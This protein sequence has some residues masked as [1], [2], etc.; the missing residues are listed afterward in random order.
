MVVELQ[1]SLFDPSLDQ[2]VRGLEVRRSADFRLIFQPR[3]CLVVLEGSNLG[4]VLI[5]ELPQ[6]LIFTDGILTIECRCS[7]SRSELIASSSAL[8]YRRAFERVGLRAVAIGGHWRLP[9]EA[10]S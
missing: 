10:R 3:Q 6:C 4:L 1:F 5:V 7:P 9:S 8:S 2:L